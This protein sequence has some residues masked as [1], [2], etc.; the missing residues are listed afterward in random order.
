MQPCQGGVV[1]MP[2][3]GDKDKVRAMVLLE[4]AKNHYDSFKLFFMQYLR[5]QGNKRHGS[6]KR[7]VFFLSRQIDELLDKGGARNED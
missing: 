5:E 1:E 3:G 2:E 4:V 6:I 7:R